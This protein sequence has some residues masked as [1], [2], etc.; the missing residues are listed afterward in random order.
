MIARIFIVWRIY[1]VANIP[2]HFGTL[3]NVCPTFTLEFL[4]LHAQF[5]RC[6]ANLPCGEYSNPL[7][8][9]SK[10]LSD[11]YARIFRSAC[12]VYPMC[13]ESTMWQIF[14]GESSMWRILWQPT[15]TW[16]C[17]E[18]LDLQLLAV[19]SHCYWWKIPLPHTLRLCL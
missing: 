14:C 10:R 5:T 3:A 12:P 18:T 9:F 11:I 6:V 2:I 7:R 17:C 13:G 19:A 16:A 1:H 8:H 4:N 15:Y